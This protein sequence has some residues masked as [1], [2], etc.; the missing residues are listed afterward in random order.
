MIKP[1]IIGTICATV[2]L[3]PIFFGGM[4]SGEGALRENPIGSDNNRLETQNTNFN[5]EQL[6]HYRI[7]GGI[8]TKDASWPTLGTNDPMETK[9][10]FGSSNEGDAD[11]DM[12]RDSPPVTRSPSGET[13][14][15]NFGD[16]SFN[17]DRNL[18]APTS[19]TPENKT[20][21]EPDLEKKPDKDDGSVD[22]KDKEDKND[23]AP[24]PDPEKE[25]D[26]E[27][28]HGED[29]EKEKDEES[30]FTSSG[31]LVIHFI[32][33]GQG[34]CILV[35]TPGGA[36]FL[37]DGGPVSSGSKVVDY[38]NDQGITRL[39]KVIATHEHADHVGGLIEV[40]ESNIEV[41]V[42]Y[43]STYDHNTNTAREFRRLAIEH[44]EYRNPEFKD[45][46]N[47]SCTDVEATFLHP[48]PR[49]EG[50]IH[51]MNLVLNVEYGHFSVLLMGDAE[52]ATE[53]ALVSNNEVF[54]YL[55]SQV[56]KVG[57]HGSRTSTGKD[58]LKAVNPKAAVIQVGSNSYG[59]P[60]KDTLDNLSDFGA[61]VYRNDLQQ[62]IVV[63][64]DGT[65]FDFNMEPYIHTDEVLIRPDNNTLASFSNKNKNNFYVM[66]I[67]EEGGLPKNNN[68]VPDPFGINSV[69]DLIYLKLTIEEE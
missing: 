12:L 36:N 37:V 56:L 14:G 59:H 44:S 47:L 6:E 43:S 35:E 13:S 26:Q 62:D 2:I 10:W 28:D 38:L 51:Y 30:P 48:Y 39:E 52:I 65:T 63:S 8:L 19:P 29:K 54:S 23:I 33:V 68:Y 9:P 21:K 66:Q 7:K 60:A 15:T 22:D 67:E 45:I 32:D 58:F 31:D 46:L 49:A 53:K 69:V 4:M 55:P 3:L 57:H 25:K 34:D 41:D 64:S 24:I 16:S 5:H 20:K 61:S 42:T 27:G 17:P 11:P 50:D 18:P 1:F 40:Y